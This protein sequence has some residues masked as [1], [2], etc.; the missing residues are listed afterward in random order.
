M[1]N[2]GNAYLVDRLHDGAEILY[3][4]R[5]TW[6]VGHLPFWLPLAQGLARHRSKGE[7]LKFSLEISRK[8]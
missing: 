6:I 8:R 1:K 5:S 3:D 4:G 7:Q 2:F